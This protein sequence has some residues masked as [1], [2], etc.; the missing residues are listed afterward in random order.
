MRKIGFVGLG[1]MGAAMARQL[2]AKQFQVVGYDI[3]PA[4]VEA[5]A[6]ADGHAAGSCAEAAKGADALIVMVVN[7]DQAEQVMFGDDAVEA[8]SDGAPVIVC[9]TCA[10][11]RAEAM[12]AKCAALGHPLI[13]APVSGGQVGAEA[14]TL[15]IMAA[16]PRPDYDKVEG[17]LKAMGSNTYFIGEK[18]GQG[19]AMKTVNQLMA[20][21]HIAVAAEAIAFAEKAGIDPALA[22]EILSG[23]AASSWML[24]N[25][26][27]EMVKQTGKVTSAVDIFVKD[28]GIVLDAGRAMRMGL[29]LAAAA[30][31]R[32]LD[33]SGAGHGREDDS[34]VVKVYRK[35][36]EG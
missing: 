35:M 27:P 13:D 31:Q 33:A 19:S 36:R 7:A 22:L 29:P 14:G 24:Q 34:Q 11:D 9:S 12:A 30:H 17:V 8:L 4:A 18:V 6:A 10:P 16:A 3:N 25:R 20:G 26:G 21:A 23:S 2:V 15:T 5:L 28:L 32:F 1:A